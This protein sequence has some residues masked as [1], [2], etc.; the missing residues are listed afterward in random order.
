MER[1]RRLLRQFLFHAGSHRNFESAPI[2]EK[3]VKERAHA[4]LKE[5]TGLTNC[6]QAKRKRLNA[7]SAYRSRVHALQIHEPLPVGL[8]RYGILR[9]SEGKARKIPLHF[10]V[11]RRPHGTRESDQCTVTRHRK[12]SILNLRGVFIWNIYTDNTTDLYTVNPVS[13]T[14]TRKL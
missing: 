6:I 1:A 9:R 10:G 4:A 5:A 13:P 12:R 3:I 7:H 11:R 2:A 14:T 8:L